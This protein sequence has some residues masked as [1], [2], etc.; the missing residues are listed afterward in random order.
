MKLCT[1]CCG[2]FDFNLKKTPE[3][4]QPE[5]PCSNVSCFNFVHHLGADNMIAI[6]NCDDG[7]VITEVTC[8]SD[9]I[10]WASWNYDGSLI[11]TTS[12]DKKIRVIDPR[13]GDVKK[14]S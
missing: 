14:V 1:T 7:S 3:S 6:W 4:Y 8:H 11:A 12:K 9:T 2:K 13:T 5:S 10:F